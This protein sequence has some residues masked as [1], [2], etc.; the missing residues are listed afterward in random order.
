[1]IASRLSGSWQ[2]AV[3]V[4]LH[5]QMDVTLFYEH[6]AAFSYSLMDYLLYAL[7]QTL[8]EERFNSFN[9]HFDGQVFRQY[10]SIN[11]GLAT[12]HPK[13]LIVPNLYGA[14]N[15]H[16]ADFTFMRKELM[17]RAKQWKHA[18]SE[19]TNGT[20]TVTNLGTMGID[21]FTPILNPPQTAILGLGR[22]K[23][24]SVITEWG[25]P[26]IPKVFIPISLSID[27]RV[28]DGAAAA[29]FLQCLEGKVQGQFCG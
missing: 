20:F 22:I 29:R 2:Q 8:K 28:L 17:N 10:A 23:M 24:E 19:L 13:G 9:S 3:H 16:L 18:P 26:P 6:K 12:D 5:K 27:H 4:T 11:L 1:M 14:E 7:V 25:S 21:F 15:M